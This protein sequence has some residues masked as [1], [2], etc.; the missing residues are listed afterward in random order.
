MQSFLIFFP[1]ASCASTDLV[2]QLADKTAANVA[3]I[4]AHLRQLDA[5]SRRIADRR[6][7]N[8]S[9]LR[10]SNAKLRARYKYDVALTKKTG[11][12]LN[13]SL[14]DDLE[15]WRAEFEQI[16]D[17]VEASGTVRREAMLETQTR[18]DTKSKALAEIAQS[19]AALA[20]SEREGD[21]VRFL[22]GYAVS[23]R[24]ELANALHE[25]SKAAEAAMVLLDKLGVTL[26][27]DSTPA[28]DRSDSDQSE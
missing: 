18:L 9:H 10:T 14:L 16:F 4:S 12:Q 23:L 20:Q 3:T 28:A 19:L 8:V 2:N 7:A 27:V 21:R 11:G 26:T 25:D 5:N 24:T 17:A 1:L 13:L 15:V 6:A 22:A